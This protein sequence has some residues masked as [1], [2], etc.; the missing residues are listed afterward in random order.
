MPER[1][2]AMRVIGLGSPFGD[3]RIGWQVATLLAEASLPAGVDAVCCENPGRDL[4]PLLDGMTW[5]I[6]VDALRG[7]GTPG[8]IV[9]CTQDDI[10]QTPDRW[11]SHGLG[12][13]E[14]LDLAASLGCLPARLE[15]IGI[16]AG[17]QESNLPGLTISPAVAL[18]GQR[19]AEM[20]RDE[21]VGTAGSTTGKP[22]AA[23]TAKNACLEEYA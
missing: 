7:N 23:P 13:A 12:V 14:M 9:R 11:S 21:L 4:L 19:L 20:L 2:P 16:E 3:D 18:G 22:V 1:A 5:V 17:N 10:V 6:L 15:I 8:D